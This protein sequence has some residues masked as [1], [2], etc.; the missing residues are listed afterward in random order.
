MVRGI[1]IRLNGLMIWISLEGEKGATI[2]KLYSFAAKL[3]KKQG[4]E[5]I[6]AKLM[7]DSKR[8]SSYK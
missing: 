6:G 3:D 5:R 4:K 7:V 8:Q 2:R 1:K